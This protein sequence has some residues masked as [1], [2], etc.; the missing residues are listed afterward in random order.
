MQGRAGEAA[1]FDSE[2]IIKR[3]LINLLLSI[4]T[5]NQIFLGEVEIGRTLHFEFDFPFLFSEAWIKLT[6]DNMVN[7]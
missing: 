7:N 5:K 6:L 1:F 2:L 4:F 3:I